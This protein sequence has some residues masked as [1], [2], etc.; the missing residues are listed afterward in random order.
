[1]YAFFRSSVTVTQ[2]PLAWGTLSL[3]LMT[4]HISA[5]TIVCV[6]VC[7]CVCARVRARVF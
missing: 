7:V 3:F 5:L 4:L 6:C 1:M 2:D